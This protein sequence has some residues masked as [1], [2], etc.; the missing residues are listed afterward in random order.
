LDRDSRENEDDRGADLL[1]ETMKGNIY[2]I[3]G[4]LVAGDVSVAT[5]INGLSEIAGYEPEEFSSPQTDQAWIYSNDNLLDIHSAS[6]FPNGTQA[7]GINDF[8]VVVGQGW[9]TS[10]SFHAFMYA[11]GQMGT[12]GRR[13]PT[14]LQPWP[15]TT[16][17][18][19]SAAL[20]SPAVAAARSFIKM[21]NSPT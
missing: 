11:N 8:G 17:D 5:C 20:S 9:L 18:K 16:T 12:S 13:V 6:L 21:A 19:S 2:K 14:R 10:S 15:S 1:S 7:F 3:R 4:T